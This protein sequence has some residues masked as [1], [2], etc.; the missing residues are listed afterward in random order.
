MVS[1][2][3]KLLDP[4]EYEEKTIEYAVD[5]NGTEKVR[6]RKTVTKRN[7]PNSAAV[8][9]ALCNQDAENFKNIQKVDVDVTSKGEQITGMVIK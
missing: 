6:S 2:L 7:M 8:I 5:S 9:F 4:I 1:G 3:A